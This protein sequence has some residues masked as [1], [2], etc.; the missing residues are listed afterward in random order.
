MNGASLALPAAT[1]I[2]SI[3]IS[4]IVNSFIDM[5]DISWNSMANRAN[6]WAG[7]VAQYMS[8]A[9]GSLSSTRGGIKRQEGVCSW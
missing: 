4:H 1:H 7:D 9:R 3:C 8:K 2:D 6:T 5:K